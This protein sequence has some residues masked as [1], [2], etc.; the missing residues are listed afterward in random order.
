MTP[1]GGSPDSHGACFAPAPKP[2][3]VWSFRVFHMIISPPAAAAAAP[4][5]AVP[6]AQLGNCTGG[7]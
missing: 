5:A 2:P 3:V 1:G 7:H 4:L 6:K